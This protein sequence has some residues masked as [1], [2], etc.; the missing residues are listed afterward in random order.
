[1]NLD[2]NTLENLSDEEFADELS[3]NLGRDSNW[4]TFLENAVVRRT[5]E[6]L[7]EMQVDV[8]NQIRK[9][10]GKPDTD[11]DWLRRASNFHGTVTMRLR[12]ARRVIRGLDAK[13]NASVSHWKNFA[14]ELVNIIEDSDLNAELDDIMIPI[15]GLTAR[16]WR[17]RRVEKEPQRANV[18][19]AEFG[20]REKAA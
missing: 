5:G 18:V 12:Q 11:M 19:Y 6:A 7:E 16:Q 3:E 15:G 14:H 17:D 10:E 20:D 2:V 13:A 9:H 8:E 4:P 1:M